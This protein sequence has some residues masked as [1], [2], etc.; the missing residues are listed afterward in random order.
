MMRPRHWLDR[1]CRWMSRLPELSDSGAQQL[2][3]NRR[4]FPQGW[5]VRRIG[6]PCRYC[7]NFGLPRAHHPVKNRLFRFG[8]WD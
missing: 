3:G 5:S 1:P 2:S 4:P 7:L 6:R 8:D